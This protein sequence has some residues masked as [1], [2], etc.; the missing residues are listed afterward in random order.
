[1][2]DGNYCVYKHTFPNGKVYIGIT[3][4]TNRRWDDGFGYQENKKMFRDIV[5]Y[6]W[7]N[8]SHEIIKNGICKAEATALERSMIRSYCNNGKENVYN[9]QCIP[10]QRLE[11][12]DEVISE[13]TILKYGKRF[14]ELDDDWVD[15]YTRSGT[16]WKIE[17][18]LN[19][20]NLVF[21]PE[22]IGGYPTVRTI[23]FLYPYESMTFK[24][25]NEWLFTKPEKNID[26]RELLK[27]AI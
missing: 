12:Y 19:G 3:N 22:L 1:M 18:K 25:V 26:K 15:A 16:Y 23:V 24:E 4:D 17:A 8:I 20:I 9:I 21:S 27:K 6:G 13:E 5:L 7:R 2:V 10:N 14:N 11:W